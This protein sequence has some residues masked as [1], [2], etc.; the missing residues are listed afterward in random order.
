MRR[1]L[2]GAGAILVVLGVAAQAAAVSG[3]LPGS[4]V[5]GPARQVLAT[6]HT[7]AFSV[8]MDDGRLS[9]AT[10]AD[11]GSR[12]GVRLDPDATVFHVTDDAR[13]AAP[14][15]SA[16]GFLGV[17]PGA[18]VHV[19]PQAYT[20]GI[21]WAGWNTERVPASAVG[22]P[23][24]L[25]VEDVRG[26]GAVEIYES[27]VDG[28]Q[29][30]LSS[31]DRGLRSLAVPANTHAHASWVFTEPG[32]YRI[33][34]GAST[35]TPQGAPL[36]ATSRTY[37]FAV[38]GSSLEAV[39]T[40]VQIAGR[41]AGE[42]QVA[43]TADVGWAARDQGW[44][45]GGRVTFVHRAGGVETD[46][47]HAPVSAGQAQLTAAPPGGGQVLARFEPTEAQLVGSATSAALPNPVAATTPQ[48][49]GVSPGYAPGETAELALEGHEALGAARAV[50]VVQPAADEAWTQDGWALSVAVDESLDGAQVT[51]ALEA[52]DG[53]RLGETPA[54][55]LRLAPAQEPSPAPT[56][57]PP[58][59]AAPEQEPTVPP[60]GD[61]VPAPDPE[62]PEGSGA[63]SPAGG[64]TTTT[65]A[66]ECI[67]TAV[68]ETVEAGQV[69]VVTEGHLDLG[70]TIQ[71]GSLVVAVKDD[72]SGTQVWRSPGELVLHLGEAARTP[73]PAGEDFS[74]LGTGH[75]WAIPLAQRTGVPWLGWNTQHPTIAG[76]ASGPMT[77]TLESVDGPGSLA[78]YSLDSF[79]GVG[80]R[81]FGTVDGFP[82]STSVPVGAAG[83][84]VH[85]IWA[86]TAEGIYR[87]TVGF[88]GTVDGAARSG[89]A[90]MTFAVGD[91]DPAGAA[92]ASTVTRYVGR[93]PDGEE[94]ELDASQAGG[95]LA[96]TGLADQTLVDL[97]VVGGALLAAGLALTALSA[98]GRE[99]R[100]RTPG[101]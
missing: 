62:V 78:V 64:A 87:V 51:A 82:R 80:D 18:P 13:R 72:R 49:T 83:V 65:A 88:S 43:L 37:V 85:G 14:T 95:G 7:D 74:F 57:S 96:R 39:P 21:L 67:P 20:P 58:A 41:T 79:G 97:G 92:Q 89:T 66:V 73:V 5:A 71:D 98:V 52:E 86:F 25:T 50:W 24:R 69:D 8:F 75:V 54:V 81:Y 68:T 9:L 12:R 36:R 76:R 35:T 28:P 90:V 23:I 30:L 55:T 15:G 47:G 19:I 16:F 17:A 60:S 26:P 38:G 84:H 22:G 53:T 59:E 44:A 61:P 56:T 31:R 33:T 27:G 4:P 11:L 6:E 3:P 99:P 29:R 34:V 70:P 1:S 94:C 32:V 93:T 63:P 91:V 46:L 48:I 45:P 77:L 40:Q 101:R 2:A 100:R 42:G 10:M